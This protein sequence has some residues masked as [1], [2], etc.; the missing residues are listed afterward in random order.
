LSKK[1]LELFILFVIYRGGGNP[2]GSLAFSKNSKLEMEF[3]E[4]RV[5]SN[6][7]RQR[8]L[9]KKCSTCKHHTLIPC[10]ILGLIL[11]KRT[12]ILV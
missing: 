5:K 6:K 10:V 12:W 11:Y 7:L 2:F 4:A 3:G 8:R 1:S 9:S